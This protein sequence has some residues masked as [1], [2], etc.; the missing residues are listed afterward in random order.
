MMVMVMVIV[1]VNGDSDGKSNGDTALPSASSLS[2]PA[3]LEFSC[4]SSRV[5]EM[6]THFNTYTHTLANTHTHTF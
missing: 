4:E 6:D 3:S 2:P 5:L 1:M